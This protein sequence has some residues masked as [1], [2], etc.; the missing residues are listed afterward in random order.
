MDWHV[1]DL[2]NVNYAQRR[3]RRKLLAQNLIGAE[4]AARG[5]WNGRAPAEDAGL[6][7]ITLR[8]ASRGAMSRATAQPRS[9][10]ELACSLGCPIDGAAGDRPTEVVDQR[11]G[12]DPRAAQTFHSDL[13]ATLLRGPHVARDGPA[14][15]ELL[16]RRFSQV[17]GSPHPLWA[18]SGSSGRRSACC[19]CS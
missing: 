12:P 11:D 6:G 18:S 8:G 1:T 9:F 7:V 15:S 5:V 10:R 2:R 16:R 14:V 19:A 3:R 17:G 4:H 13:R